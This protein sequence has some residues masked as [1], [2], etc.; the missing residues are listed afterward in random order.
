MVPHA[1]LAP[2]RVTAELVDL[3]PD[4]R[5]VG[6]SGHLRRGLQPGPVHTNPGPSAWPSPHKSYGVANACFH[7]L[8]TQFNVSSPSS[9]GEH[10][11]MPTMLARA[12][13]WAPQF[14]SQHYMAGSSKS[15]ARTS[16]HSKESENHSSWMWKV[17]C[18]GPHLTPSWPT[19]LSLSLLL[20]LA[21]PAG[22]P[23]II[24]LSEV[25]GWNRTPLCVH[26]SATRPLYG[27]SQRASATN[28]A[29]SR[30]MLSAVSLP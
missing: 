29:A 2:P 6:W 15:Q 27:R 25:L 20:P 8:C 23:T 7:G 3:W 26:S 5:V 13:L 17:G 1:L 11:G 4:H 30:R 16:P 14:H 24:L 10:G 12:Y 28:T 19:G 21:W 9:S 22:L 18:S